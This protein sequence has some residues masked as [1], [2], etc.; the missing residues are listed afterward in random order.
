M[1][2]EV[3]IIDVGRNP[4]FVEDWRKQNYPLTKHRKEQL[5]KLFGQDVESIKNIS[6][7]IGRYP[8]FVGI[9]WVLPK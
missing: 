9:R 7:N 3:E 8:A 2:K 1:T 6:R 4:F 5:E